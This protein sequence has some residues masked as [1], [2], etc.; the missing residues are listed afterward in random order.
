MTYVAD[1]QDRDDLT[2]CDSSTDVDACLDDLGV[3]KDYD[4]LFVK[5]EDGAYTEVYG[6]FGIIPHLHKILDRIV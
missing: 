2:F 3:E 5:V 1:I 4:A 6:M